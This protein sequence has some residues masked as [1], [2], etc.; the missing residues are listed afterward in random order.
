MP[1]AS[2]LLFLAKRF[3]GQM[4]LGVTLQAKAGNSKIQRDNLSKNLQK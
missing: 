4:Y 3:E 2:K 1:G